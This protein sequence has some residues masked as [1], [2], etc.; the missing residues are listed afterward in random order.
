MMILAIILYFVCATG[1]TVALVAEAGVRGPRAVASYVTASDFGSF[2]G[3]I[4]GW[5]M[6]QLALPIE[7]IFILGGCLYGVAGCV[8]FLTFEK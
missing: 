1:A 8:A 2:A 4:L 3:P 7:W 6:P 5:S